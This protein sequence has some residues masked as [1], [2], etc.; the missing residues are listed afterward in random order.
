MSTLPAISLSVRRSFGRRPPIR[1]SGFSLVAAV[2]LVVTLAGLGTFM[3]TMSAVQQKTTLLALQGS[4]A[5]RAVR[6][7]VE[8]ALHQVLDP[9]GNTAAAC[10]AAPSNP[11]VNT[12]ALT[13]PGL[14][15]FTVDVTCSYTQHQ[16][17]PDNF[18]VF[19]IDAVARYGAFGQPD[20]ASRTLQVTATDL[21]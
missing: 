5:E 7:G 18:N 14:T 4:R 19:A 8:W 9:A 20:F 16:Q 15:G 2:F 1:E 12:L 3:V 6:S 21:F 13:V 11:T 10:G 17:G